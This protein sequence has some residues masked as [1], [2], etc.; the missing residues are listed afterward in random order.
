MDLLDLLNSVVR[1]IEAEFSIDDAGRTTA[2]I[3]KRREGKP[4]VVDPTGDAALETG[5]RDL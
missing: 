5:R 1:S 3:L 4:H 2:K